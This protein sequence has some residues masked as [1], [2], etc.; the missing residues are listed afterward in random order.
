MRLKPARFIDGRLRLPGDKS[1]S[2]RAA[3][4]AALADGS[5]EISN[6]ST[7][8]DCASTL[9]CLREL[10]ITIERSNDKVTFAGS[11]KLVA[12]RR[13]LDCGNSGSTLRILAGVLAGHDF[14][15]ELIGDASLSSRPMRRIIEPLEMMGAKIEATDGKAPLKVHGS[16]RLNPITYKLP[17]ASAQ[18]K[19]AIL[20]AGLNAEGRTTVI[21]TSP[22][23]DHTERLFNGFGVP[24]ITNADLSVTLDGPARFHGGSITIPGDV[25]SAAYFVAAAMLL[26]RSRL[27]IEGAGLNPTRAAFL[28]VLTSWGADIATDDLQTERNEPFGT[29]NVRGGLTGTATESDRTLKRAMIP[30]LIDELP[31]LAVVGSQIEGGIQIRDAAELRH[32]ESDRLATTAANLRAMGAEVE[33]FDDGLAVFG[34]A[35]LH[36]AQIDSHGD[37]R[38]A[39]AFS[40]AALI[41]KGETEITGAE[42]VAISFPEFFT[43]LESAAQR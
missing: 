43:L 36:G 17:V 3:L 27:T 12:P 26:P 33:E 39:M 1:I 19:S 14:T 13:P 28:S 9:A 40:V 32:K 25:S 41:A 31:L 5:T 21:E 37:H 20:F 15:A 16:S 29:I 42:C 24:V 23:R 30:S 35:Q 38:I 22:S 10:G 11:Q 2:H 6:F 34:P 4:I 7:A 8:A 18:V